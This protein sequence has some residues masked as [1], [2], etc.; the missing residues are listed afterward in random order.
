VAQLKTYVRPMTGWWRRNPFYVWYMVR[1]A[2]C[3]FIT[4]YALVLL[5][6][7]WRLSQGP[8][9]FDAWRAALTTPTSIAFHFVALVLV[10]YHSW[11]W[12]KIMPKTMPFVRIRGQRI[13]DQTIVASGVTAAI[14]ASVVLFIV[15][16]WAVT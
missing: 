6:G 3:V 12:F 4:L 13:T 9:A 10:I 5:A 7:L 16:R 15:V 2:S 1:E 8:A 14:V 11:T